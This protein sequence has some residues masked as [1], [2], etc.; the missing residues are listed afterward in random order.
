MPRIHAIFDAL[1]SRQLLLVTAESL[2]G[3][4]IA[5]QITDIPGASDMFWGG[6]V[7]YSVQAKQQLLSVPKETV[8]RFG[9]VSIE[10][11]KAM[12]EGALAIASASSGSRCYALAVTG[13]AGPS[14]GTEETPVGTVCIACAGNEHAPFCSCERVRFHGTRDAIREQTYTY[15]LYM[16]SRELKV[17]AETRP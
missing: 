8:E 16:L 5:K 13:L 9:V 4:L 11:A 12:A 10:T 2:T 1:K 14:G 15:A 3:G 7:T 6:F 17:P